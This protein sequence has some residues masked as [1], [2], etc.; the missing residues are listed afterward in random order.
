MHLEHKGGNVVSCTLWP[1]S[2][3]GDIPAGEGV[4]KRCESLECLVNIK[5]F[6]EELHAM[7]ILVGTDKLQ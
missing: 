1:P 5:C 4:H 6:Q 2:P 3:A 7:V